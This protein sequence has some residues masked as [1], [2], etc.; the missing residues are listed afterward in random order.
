MNKSIIFCSLLTDFDLFLRSVN[1]EEKHFFHRAS[2]SRKRQ[3]IFLQ[4]NSNHSVE[5]I[6]HIYLSETQSNM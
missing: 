3:N 6:Q 4:H 2:Y 5:N 1:T